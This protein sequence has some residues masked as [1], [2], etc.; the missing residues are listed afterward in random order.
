[1]FT[2]TGV[3]SGG[4]LEGKVGSLILWLE[5][6]AFQADRYGPWTSK[7]VLCLLIQLG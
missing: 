2:P 5:L 7:L 1:M 4:Q 3:R 6:G